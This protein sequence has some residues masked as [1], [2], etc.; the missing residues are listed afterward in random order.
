[1]ER[2]PMLLVQAPAPGVLWVNGQCVFSQGDSWVIPAAPTG[3]VILQYQGFGSTLPAL[4]RV[5]FHA[6]MPQASEG[7]IA[8]HAVVFW[9]NGVAQVQLK[10]QDADPVRMVDTLCGERFSYQLYKGGGVT[11]T[12]ED[13]N[14]R[15][16]FSRH[17]PD[18]QTGS[19]RRLAEA[20]NAPAALLVLPDAQRLVILKEAKDA[21]HIALDETGQELRIGPQ[22]QIL[23]ACTLFD[24]VF[25]RT[26]RYERRDGVYHL[27]DE[28]VRQ[29][30]APNLSGDWSCDAY[31]TALHLVR[32]LMLGCTESMQLCTCDV[33][34]L[35][36][37]LGDF[38]AVCVSVLC[39]M[40][41]SDCT[42]AVLH[43]AAPGIQTARVFGFDVKDGRVE[44]FRPY[45]Q[46]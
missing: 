33:S 15:V 13:E 32:G 3:E 43:T 29:N 19:L 30:R 7:D 16:C 21:A 27:A 41:D 24:G 18:A 36:L 42:L 8:P 40:T 17:F 2:M 23:A 35:R 20:E 34:T 45:A 1:M 26:R 31:D 39:P 9:P 11:L 37:A 28:Q 46:Q 44:A 25:S 12:C 22:G 4:V 6:G 38:D 14:E 5:R 10:P